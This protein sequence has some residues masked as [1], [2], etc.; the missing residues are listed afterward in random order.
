MGV[1]VS[2]ACITCKKDYYCGYGS[3]S[4]IETRKLRFPIAEHSEHQLVYYDEDYTSEK[5]GDLISS[6]PPDWEEKIVIPGFSQ[7]DF[8]DLLES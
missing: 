8:V 4:S 5:N 3:Y 7:F 1:G 2:V 6:F